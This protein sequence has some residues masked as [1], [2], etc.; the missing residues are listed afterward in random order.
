VNCKQKIWIE[1]RSF[2]GEPRPIFL[3]AVVSHPNIFSYF[4]CIIWCLD[5]FDT[6]INLDKVTFIWKSPKYWW[7]L[8]FLEQNSAETEFTRAILLK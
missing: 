2:E 7:G 5:R 6:P 1:R 3:L 8:S 4:R